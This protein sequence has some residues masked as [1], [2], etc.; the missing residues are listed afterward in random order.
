LLDLAVM[1]VAEPPPPV[2]APLAGGAYELRAEAFAGCALALVVVV[3]LLL[4]QPAISPVRR[5]A[6]VH[7]DLALI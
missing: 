7:R 1:T 6:A 2:A 5:I 3:L 4:P